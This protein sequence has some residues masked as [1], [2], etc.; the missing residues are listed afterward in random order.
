MKVL[1]LTILLAVLACCYCNGENGASPKSQAKA[2]DPANAVIASGDTSIV[3]CDTML[4]PG[5]TIYYIQGLYN[6]GGKLTPFEKYVRAPDNLPIRKP[7]TTAIVHKDPNPLPP[8]VVKIVPDIWPNPYPSD[9][10]IRSN[11]TSDAHPLPLNPDSV[12]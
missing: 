4:L 12:K 3:K 8:G 11:I 9:S 1:S 6:I 7:D 5:D 10:V 2:A